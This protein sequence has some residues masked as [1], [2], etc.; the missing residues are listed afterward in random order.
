MARGRRHGAQTLRRRFDLGTMTSSGLIRIVD[1]YRARTGLAASGE[2]SHFRS[3][4][5]LE[6]AVSAAA[7]ARLNGRKLSHQRRIPIHVLEMGRQRLLD[8]LAALMNAGCST[9]CS[10]PLRRSLG[11]SSA[12]VSSPSTT[13][14]F[15][16]APDLT[17][18]RQRSTFTLG[19]VRARKRSA[20]IGGS[21]RFSWRHY[22]MSCKRCLRVRPKT[23]YVSTRITSGRR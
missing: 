10:I 12:S 3:L 18:N 22:R 7:L 16:S 14:H 8:N 13:L 4:A 5:K 1:D 19:P 2:L 6:D 21:R 15:A 17:S 9:S 20:L 11:R 23:F